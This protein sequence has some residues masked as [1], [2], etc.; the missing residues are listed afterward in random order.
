MCSFLFTISMKEVA[1]KYLFYL[2]IYISTHCILLFC[3][4]ILDYYIFKCL[5]QA[6]TNW[7]IAA[8]IRDDRDHGTSSM[9]SSNDQSSTPHSPSTILQL[10]CQQHPRTTIVDSKRHA[11]L[12]ALVRP[13]SELL[14][15]PFHK[16]LLL[17]ARSW[18]SGDFLHIFSSVV[19]LLGPYSPL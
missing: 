8:I 15:S 12:C 3:Q 5:S 6:D 13:F 19:F 17:P 1:C 4:N 18:L 7:F 16:T 10:T 2:H 14:H 11:L 9:F